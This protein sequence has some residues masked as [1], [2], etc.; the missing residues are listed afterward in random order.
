MITTAR[1]TNRIACFLSAST[2]L[3]VLSSPWSASAESPRYLSHPPLR[4]AAGPSNRPMRDGPARFIDAGR[5][6]DSNTGTEDSPWKTIQQ[7]VNQLVAGDTLYLR[8]GTYYENVYVASIGDAGAPI[9]IRSYPGEVAIIDGGM[10]E[11]FE[12]PTEIWRSYPEG[13]N[14]EF[15]STR[16]YLNIRHVVGSF[17]DSMVGLHSYFHAIDLRAKNEF[18]VQKPD[19]SDIEPL[20]CGP[21]I[22]YDAKTG[23]LHARFAHTNLPDYDNYRGETHPTKLPLVLA[24]LRSVPLR[25]AGAKHINVQD[26]IIRGGGHD[27]V[28]LEQCTNIE[29]DNVTIWCGTF[30]VRA[31]GAQQLRLIRCGIFGNSPPWQTRYDAGFNT[32]PGRTT[33][34]ISR[35]NTHAWLLAD[36]NQEYDV[37]CFPFNDDWEIAYCDFGDAGADGLYLGGVNVRFHHNLVDN[38]TDDGIYL[39]PM[40]PRH[41]YLRSGAKIYL[42]QNYFSRALTML[43]YGGTDDTRDIIYFYRNIVDLRTPIR[44][45][46]PKET[47]EPVKPYAGKLMG[48]HGG[49]PWPSMMSYHN[50]FVAGSPAYSADMW[51]L[52][53]ANKERPRR[54][55]N[56]ILVHGSKW[57]PLAAGNEFA[58]TDGNL[59]W[60]PGLEPETQERQFGDYRKSQAF[61]DSQKFYPAGFDSQSSVADPKFMKWSLNWTESNDYRLNQGS[62][63]VDAGVALPSDWPD[64]LREKDAGKPDIG[65]LPSGIQPFAVGR[66][67]APVDAGNR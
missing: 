51:L 67:A 36:A 44:Q 60:M 21:G 10:R 24:P 16:K 3:L 46:R 40:Y 6:N 5:G 66:I 13:G 39:S 33:R 20:Y 64:P 59:Y 49:P 62:P 50:T 57:L 35:L 38:T 52:R 26:L 30:G 4:L 32:Y 17:G 8:G 37:F 43:A 54:M 19:K 12:R 22:W 42:Y 23:Y 15:I 28:L 58:H 41:F 11:F 29:F 1:K 27:T 25:I 55:F 53:G 65:A 45:G 9:T 56:N 31:T 63:A 18:V 61:S 47:G 7:G 14:G 34:D 48:D 2:C